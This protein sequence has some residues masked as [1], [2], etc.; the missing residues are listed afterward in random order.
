TATQF[1]LYRP[2][3]TDRSQC[4]STTAAHFTR[5]VPHPSTGAAYTG[6]QS[7]ITLTSTTLY[8]TALGTASANAVIT[9]GAGKTITVVKDTGFVYAS[10]S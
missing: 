4:Q 1:A 8:F 5:I 3:A 10:A 7:G 6:S 2:G 9:V